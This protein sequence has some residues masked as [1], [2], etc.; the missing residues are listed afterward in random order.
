VFVNPGLLGDP[1]FKEGS[2]MSV[3]KPC[4]FMIC[5][6]GTEQ[7]CLDKGLFGDRDWRLPYLKTIVHGD[8]GFL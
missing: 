1:N 8:I 2:E 6:N 3:G 5:T 7:E 4:F